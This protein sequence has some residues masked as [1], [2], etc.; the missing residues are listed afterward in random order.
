MK[1][2]FEIEGYH[3]VLE[4]VQNVYPVGKDKFY[5]EWGFKYCSGIFEF[6]SYKTK[7]E[8]VKVHDNFV[9]AINSYWCNND[10]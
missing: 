6:F 10:K 3:V 8:A 4:Y 5:W 7:G 1:S 9:E 2:I